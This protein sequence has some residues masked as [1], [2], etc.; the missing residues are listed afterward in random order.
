M[1]SSLCNLEQSADIYYNNISIPG[2]KSK[3]VTI[4]VFTKSMSVSNL[5]DS[6]TK[7]IRLIDIDVDAG[8]Q[9][10]TD[11]QHMFLKFTKHLKDSLPS[12]DISQSSPGTP[13]RQQIL[14]E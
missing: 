11:Q 3:K 13:K 1:T 4:N 12:S 7:K 2:Y 8:E 14:C 9:K 10:Q 5:A 6:L